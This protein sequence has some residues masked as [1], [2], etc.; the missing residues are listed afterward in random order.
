M[1]ELFAEQAQR[2]SVLQ[3]DRGGQREAVHQ[4]ADGRSFFRHGDEQFAGLAVGIEADGDVAL[5]VPDLELVRDRSALFLQAVAHGAGRSVH[6]LF[7]ETHGRV[8]RAHTG[9]RAFCGLGACGRQRL[10]FLA[11]VAIDGYCFQAE[12]PGLDVGFADVF[13]RSILREI[14]RLRDRSGDERLSGGHHAEMSHVGDGAGAFGR[15]EGAIEDGQMV[16]L[17]VRRA[18]DGAGGVDVADDGVGLIMGVAQLEQRRRHGVVDDLNHAAAD[19]LLV[20]DQCQIRLDTSSIAV[21]HET[22]GAGGGQD[23]Y[24]A[25]SVA[26][27]F[28]VGQGFVPALFAG[29]VDCRWDI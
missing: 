5:V 9:G 13:D 27:F 3:R 28:A 25:V 1:R 29:L 4:A 23:C 2:D 21:H 20:L 8:A 17:D 26:M 15:L 22:D 16:V 11:A 7:L 12:L 24:L 19:Q 14:D 18:F 10:R 6:V